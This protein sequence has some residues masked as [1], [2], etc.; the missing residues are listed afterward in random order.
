MMRKI[1][2][3]RFF[4]KLF[5]W[6]YWPFHIVYSPMYIYWLWL[7]IKT[8]SF[9]FF[10]TANPSI[11]NG[12]FLMESK[13]AIYDLIPTEYY[14]PTIFFKKGTHNEEIVGAIREKQLKFPLIGK[15]DIGMQ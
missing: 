4:I 1:S 6:E 15:P 9:F 3:H 13:K 11:V 8:R 7:S 5:H 2:Y 14:P 12:G 10:N